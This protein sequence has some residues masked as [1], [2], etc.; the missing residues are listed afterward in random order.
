MNVEVFLKKQ[1]TLRLKVQ[2]QDKD[3]RTKMEPISKINQL[4]MIYQ[5]LQYFPRSEELMGEILIFQDTDAMCL[6]LM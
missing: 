1:K 5:Q 6:Y 3:R 2:I 4:S